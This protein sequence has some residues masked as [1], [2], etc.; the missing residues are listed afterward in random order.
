VLAWQASRWLRVPG[1]AARASTPGLGP[2]PVD[3]Q[4]ISTRSELVQAF[5]YLA[6]LMF[7]MQARTWNH[8]TV[9]RSFA[10][11]SASDAETAGQL[12]AL[13]E[14][15]RYTNGADPLLIA[16]RDRARLAVAQLAGVASR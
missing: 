16:D 7:G 12:A 10:A 13:Y 15:A 6:L 8:S 11:R 14:Q 4:Q 1:H 5:D 3:P 9:A 2:W